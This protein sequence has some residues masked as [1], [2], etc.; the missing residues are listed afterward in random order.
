MP[1]P[2]KIIELGVEMDGSVEGR[3]VSQCQNPLSVM[4]CAAITA[5]DRSPLIFVPSG[6]KLN[7]QHY[8]SDI[9]EAELLP[10][11]FDGA[12][13]TLQQDSAPSHYSKMTQNWIQAHI[14]AFISKDEWLSRSLDLN[15]LDF[16]V[17][18]P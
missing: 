13:W 2:P 6:M 5:I 15:P 7:R 9:L 18:L 10:K 4:V 16:S 8:I 11:H 3:R 1:K 14:P 17:W 12:P